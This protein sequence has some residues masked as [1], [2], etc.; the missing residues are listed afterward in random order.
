MSDE[1]KLFTYLNKSKLSSNIDYEKKI[2]IAILG[3]F[4]LYG[5][6]VYDIHKEVEM[7]VKNGARLVVEPVKG[8]DDRLTVFL[9]LN[10][11]NT[12]CNL[13]ELVEIKKQ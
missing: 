3:G 9:L 8:F 7:M 6:E 1:E 11:K 10:M 2:Q 13:I 12:K 5:L 4:T